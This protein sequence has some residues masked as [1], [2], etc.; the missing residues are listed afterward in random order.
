MMSFF[1]E[2]V[3]KE[4]KPQKLQDEADFMRRTQAQGE[5]SRTKMPVV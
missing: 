5:Q 1:S 2:T 3:S 4:L